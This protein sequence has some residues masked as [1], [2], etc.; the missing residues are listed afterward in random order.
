V[1]AGPTAGYL[2]GCLPAVWLVGRLAERGFD[3]RFGT[4]ALAF[5]A[6]EAVV[7][8]FG[9]PWLARFVGP[10]RA[11]VAGFW[12]FLPGTIVKAAVAGTALYSFRAARKR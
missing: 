8:L 12:P 11:L 3:R 9:V 1:L 4:A 10:E 2:I 7:Y 5:L 6:G